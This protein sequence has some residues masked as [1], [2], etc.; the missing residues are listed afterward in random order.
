[1]QEVGIF[2]YFKDNK[3]NKRSSVFDDILKNQESM[4]EHRKKKLTEWFKRM[5]NEKRGENN[6]S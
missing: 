3:A 2:G 5:E 4:E 6:D 1:M